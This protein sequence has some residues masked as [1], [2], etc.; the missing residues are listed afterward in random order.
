LPLLETRLTAANL[1]KDARVKADTEA[2]LARLDALR[3]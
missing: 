1:R 2:R 3:R